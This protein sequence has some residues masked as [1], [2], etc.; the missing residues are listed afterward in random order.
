VYVFIFLV[1][2]ALFVGIKKYFTKPPMWLAIVS[3]LII[4]LSL[5]LLTDLGRKVGD[6]YQSQRTEMGESG[7]NA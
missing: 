5:A 4:L 7:D 3:L 6:K 1:G 2:V